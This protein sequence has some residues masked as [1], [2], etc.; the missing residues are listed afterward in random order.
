MHKIVEL[1]FT[2]RKGERDR[3]APAGTGM[4]DPTGLDID[5]QTLR[6]SSAAR[7]TRCSTS[8]AMVERLSR[9]FPSARARTRTASM[10]GASSHLVRT[11]T[12]LSRSSP[13]SAQTSSGNWN[14]YPRGGERAPRRSTRRR[15]R[16][17]LLAGNVA[18]PADPTAQPPARMSF[19]SGSL[20]LI[21]LEP[22]GS[23]A[24]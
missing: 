15:G 11:A 4:R 24:H 6:L 19:V 9:H 8:R 23:N 10:P 3:D 22:I 17:Y 2:M 12:A 7:T 18:P 20:E 1:A 21:V 14:T 16:I 13:N 5:T